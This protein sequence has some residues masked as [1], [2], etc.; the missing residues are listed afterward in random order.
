MMLT[1]NTASIVSTAIH[2]D[3]MMGTNDYIEFAAYTIASTATL[4]LNSFYLFAMGMTE[5]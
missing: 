4:R 5:A 3:V 1:T 2:C